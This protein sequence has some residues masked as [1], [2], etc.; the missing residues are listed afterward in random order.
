VLLIAD[1]QTILRR[2]DDIN[3][4]RKVMTNSPVI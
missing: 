4:S 3:E 2:E 1:L